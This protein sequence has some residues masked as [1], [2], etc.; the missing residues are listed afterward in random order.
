MWPFDRVAD[1]ETAKAGAIGRARD[2]HVDVMRR[3]FRAALRPAVWF[4]RGAWWLLRAWM[5]HQERLKARREL[6]RMDDH[7]LRDI[8]ISR[9]DIG[10]VV[11]HGR[12]MDLRSIASPGLPSR[13]AA[14]PSPA[15]PLRR[16]GERHA[17]TCNAACR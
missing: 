1:L 8:G 6:E 11:T 16:R 5:Q 14:D 17:A 10:Y 9:A 7:Q 2:A 12:G 4:A 3:A 15:V 13:S